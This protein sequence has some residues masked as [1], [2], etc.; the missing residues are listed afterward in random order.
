M[1]INNACKITAP[2][3]FMI[4]I[5]IVFPA[6]VEST[7]NDLKF[8]GFGEIIKY[9]EN[10]NVVYTQTVHNRLV[11]TGEDFLLDQ[12]FQDGTTSADDVQIGSI[13]LFQGTINTA[14]TE[15][16]ADFDGDNTLTEDNCEEDTTVTTTSST[17]VI[18]PITFDAG[19]VNA[20]DGDTIAAIGICQNDTTDDADFANCATEGILFAIVDTTDVTLNTG[21]TV[22]ITYT[23]DITSAST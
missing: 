15:T 18:G 2:V 17:A 12:T 16:A 8:Y 21:E 5:M 11:D 22:Q 1:K 13:C 6:P 4:T 3:L 7:S 20:A 10:G 19:G 14:E 9:D 23:F